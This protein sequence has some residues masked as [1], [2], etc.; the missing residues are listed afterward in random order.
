MARRIL[1]RLALALAVLLGAYTAAF[2]I[3]YVMPGDPVTA[4]AA[5]G[6]EAG[7]VVGSAVD[8]VTAGELL[9]RL[10]HLALSRGQVAV[11]VDGVGVE[12]RDRGNRIQL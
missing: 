8:A 6:L 7:G 10:R 12:E 4:M 1:L 5:G 9:Q 2:L 3:L 11:R